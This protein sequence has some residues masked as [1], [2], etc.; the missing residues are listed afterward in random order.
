[1]ALGLRSHTGARLLTAIALNGGANTDW[2]SDRPA[3]VVFSIHLAGDFLAFDAREEL[4]GGVARQAV[5]ERH[6]GVG[7]R[8]GV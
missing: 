7:G 1:M 2:I 8:A 3:T 4:I 6:F 5:R